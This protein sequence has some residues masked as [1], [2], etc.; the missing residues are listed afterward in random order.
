MNN[1][2]DDLDQLQAQRAREQDAIPTVIPARRNT[3]V[4]RAESDASRADETETVPPSERVT[5]RPLKSQE[6]I[7]EGVE[8]PGD[9]D[10]AAGA[11]RGR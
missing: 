5:E 4:A 7:R 8:A 9:A 6:R 11:R 3:P 1:E 2:D 10:V